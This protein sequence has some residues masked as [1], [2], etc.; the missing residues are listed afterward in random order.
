MFASVAARADKLV[1]W[2]PGSA[3]LEPTAEGEAS[4]E[5]RRPRT[6]ESAAESADGHHPYALTVPGS[7]RAGP[8]DPGGALYGWTDDGH[9]PD[10]GDGRPVSN[11][12]ISVGGKGLSPGEWADR[13]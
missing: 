1:P 9:G 11:L 10:R 4:I 7:H 13:G 5:A 12:I 8:G 6:A 2:F 3:C